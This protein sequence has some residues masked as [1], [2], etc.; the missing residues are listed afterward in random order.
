MYDI[1]TTDPYQSHKI[2]PSERLE[3]HLNQR[4]AWFIVFFCVGFIFL[5]V[6]F[7]FLFAGP[8]LPRFSLINWFTVNAIILAVN[9]IR[10]E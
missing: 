4:D 5:R 2:I 1:V 10:P 7:I 3:Q 6:S 9:V 8:V